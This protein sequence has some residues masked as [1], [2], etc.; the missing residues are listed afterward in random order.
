[1]AHIAAGIAPD[2]SGL[3]FIV[4]PDGAVNQQTVRFFKP[5]QDS[6][7]GF[8]ETRRV[9]QRLTVAAVFDKQRHVMPR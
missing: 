1:M 5:R 7:I 6:V 3:Q 8:T 2:A 9:E 4:L